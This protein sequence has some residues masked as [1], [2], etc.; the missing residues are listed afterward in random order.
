MAQVPSSRSVLSHSF[1][2]TSRLL[3]SSQFQLVFKQA[4]FKAG[5]NSFLFL[6][7]PNQHDFARLGLVVGK[8]HCKLAVGRN[9]LKRHIRETFRHHQHKLGGIDAIVLARA[10]AANLSATEL[11][12]VLQKQWLK[13]TRVVEQSS[14]AEST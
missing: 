13:L 10:G 14:E 5:S 8:K 7:R 6:A 12:S 3:T 9:R 11:N 1:P 4:K 2:K